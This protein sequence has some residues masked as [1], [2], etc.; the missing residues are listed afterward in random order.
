MNSFIEN[1]ENVSNMKYTEN[2][3][4]AYSTTKSAV[5][6]LFALGGAYR[7]RTEDEKI[8]LFQNALAEDATLAVKC[9]FYLRDVRGGQGEREFFRVAYRHLARV[10]A[11]TAIRNLKYIPE[12]GRWDDLVEIAF[13]S[14]ILFDEAIYL[15]VEQ[16]HVDMKFDKPS[17]LAKW[18]PSENT[19]SAKTKQKA[20]VIR[21]ALKLT[22]EKYR[23]LLSTLRAR[24]GIVESKMSANDWS[25][26]EYDKLPSR[27]GF[28]HSEAFKRH[29]FDRYMSFVN[30]AETKVNA[31]TLYPHEIVQKFAYSNWGSNGLRNRPSKKDEKLYQ[32]YWDNLPNYLADSNKSILCVVDTSGSMSGLPIDVAAS[33]GIY[34]AERLRGEF[35]N[36]IVTFSENPHF[37]KLPE[38][39]SIVDKVNCVLRH[40]EVA[41][42][43]LE[44]TFK[45]LKKVALRSNPADIPSTLVILSDMEIDSMAVE[46]VSEDN[47][48]SL[49][50]S[51]RK[52]WER[53][54]LKMPHLVYWN[55][56]GRNDTLLEKPSCGVTFV[57][58]FSSVLFESVT[59]GKT[60]IELMLDKLLSKR[61]A[62]IAAL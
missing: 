61:Y 34:C 2:G 20:R 3:A 45:L 60:G 14:S 52:D 6:D 44:A 59:S 41:K 24:I 11:D 19:S 51:I 62:D 42:T 48:D 8:R 15:I 43:N 39:G 36:S 10:S 22:S 18:L 54:G 47:M 55:V 5:Y 32:K 31:R 29:D 1:L 30:S 23:K 9:L 16:L 12:F 28:L 57:S 27:A 56:D 53:A 25:E 46:D 4:R 58:G 50:E 17:L 38:N 13:S 26:I 37:I 21:H 35:H 40:S 7:N 33:L 49:M